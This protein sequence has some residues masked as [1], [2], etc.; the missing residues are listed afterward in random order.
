MNQPSPSSP[1]CSRRARLVR[2]LERA[3]FSWTELD[4]FLYVLCAV[5][6]YLALSM[7]LSPS[8]SAEAAAYPAASNYAVS[9][10]IPPSSPAEADTS[11]GER[12]IPQPTAPPLRSS[13]VTSTMLTQRLTRLE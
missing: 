1:C 12:K 3:G 6:I 11:R 10:A 8:N 13:P 9:P 7:L 4:P 2:H 5:L